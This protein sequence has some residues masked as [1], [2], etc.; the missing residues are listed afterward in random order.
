MLKSLNRR[1]ILGTFVGAFIGTLV[2]YFTVGQWISHVYTLISTLL[3]A[4]AGYHIGDITSSTISLLKG[5]GKFGQFLVEILGEKGKATAYSFQVRR[6]AKQIARI[7]VS[8]WYKPHRPYN[9]TRFVRTW[10]LGLSGLMIIGLYTLAPVL[11]HPH[12]NDFSWV[13]Y[14]LTGAS[15]IAGVFWAGHCMRKRAKDDPDGYPLGCREL[16]HMGAYRFFMKAFFA[17]FGSAAQMTLYVWPVLLA[18]VCFGLLVLAICSAFL[19]CVAVEIASLV[20]MFKVLVFAVS[21]RGHWFSFAIASTTIFLSMW[22]RP[23]T[24]DE[25]IGVAVTIACLNAGVAVSMGL[26]VRIVMQRIID[27]YHLEWK[28]IRSSWPVQKTT[29]LADKW[30]WTPGFRWL[31]NLPEWLSKKVPLVPSY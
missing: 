29:D 1:D 11:V 27:R 26:L 6:R 2:S 31:I 3:G 17:S 20:F 7:R 21:K 13:M 15:G 12:W 30:L 14:V 25:S 23:W 22:L 10:A 4:A 5:S 24:G 16:L 19:F 18:M 9:Y 8:N 28:N